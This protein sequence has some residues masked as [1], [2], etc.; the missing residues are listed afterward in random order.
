MTAMTD[1]P[2]TFLYGILV[3]YRESLTKS[4]IIRHASWSPYPTLFPKEAK[5]HVN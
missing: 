1:F 5:K 3:L 4:V 2:E